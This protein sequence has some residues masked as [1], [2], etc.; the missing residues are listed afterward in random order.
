LLQALEYWEKSCTSCSIALHLGKKSRDCQQAIR[1]PKAKL[2]RSKWSAFP[3][4]SFDGTYI[5][6]LVSQP[7]VLQHLL[8]KAKLSCHKRALDVIF[9]KMYVLSWSPFCTSKFS[10]EQIHFTQKFGRAKRLLSLYSSPCS[11]F[12]LYI[13]TP[14]MYRSTKAS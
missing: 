10:F 12:W 11:I 3:V 13:D 1:S 6:W 9:E 14:L 5:F 7:G 8:M 4:H 2:H